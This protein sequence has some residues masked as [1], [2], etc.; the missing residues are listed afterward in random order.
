M[1][2]KKLNGTGIDIPVIG[3]GTW[4]IAPPDR[5]AP[6][7]V[8]SER[9]VDALKFG[10]E[11][12]LT[13]IDTAEVYGNGTSEELIG[14]AIKG[15]PRSEL[16]ISTKVEPEHFDYEGVF[17]AVKG[18]MKRM[19][20][21]YVDLYQLHRPSTTVPIEET[22]KAMEQLVDKGIIRFIGI[23][24]FSA[25]QMEHAQN[26]MSRHKIVSNQVEYNVLNRR[27]E[28]DLL[29]IARGRQVTIIAYSPFDTG[30]L[31]DYEGDG[32]QV[33]SRLAQKYSKSVA[34][35][36]LNWLIHHENVITIPKSVERAHLD[37][38]SKASGWKMEE[39]DYRL[40]DRAFQKGI[41]QKAR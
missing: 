19:G 26:V 11:K 24:N 2:T 10:I 23:S 41:L 4:N 22:M 6:D 40:I 13:H 25:R 32:A 29:D 8:D 18:S 33:V 15:I 12:G 5:F 35:I 16:F 14:Q 36:Y 3:M 28:D 1:E 9:V 31:F 38:N 20:I 17:E 30:G 27:I 39:D 34:Q 37:E 21:S 7:I